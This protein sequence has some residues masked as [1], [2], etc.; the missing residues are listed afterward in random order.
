M[1]FLRAVWEQVYRAW[2]T[3]WF[4]LL[5]LLVYPLLR[6]LISRPEWKPMAHQVHRFWGSAALTLFGMPITIEGREKLD[7]KNGRYVFAP[8][9]SSY[10]DIPL[11]LR[12]IPGFLN[13]VGKSSLARVPL[14]GKIYGAL[15]ICVDRKSQIS[16]A[17]SYAEA[18]NSLDQGRCVTIF[19]EGRIESEISGYALL[20]FQNGPF[21]LAIEKQVPLVP[22]TMP[23]NHYFLPDAQGRL[24]VRYH[25]LKIIFHEPVPTTGMTHHDVEELKS[26]VFDIIQTELT[27]HHY[28][29]RPSDAS[30]PGSLSPA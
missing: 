25:P 15:Y 30:R 2:C 23:Y 17:R 14:W 11:M 29:D 20:P 8:N 5:F 18:K 22:V 19:P 6:I 27:R 28:A 4:G 24:V 9:H 3:F 26:R 10:I 13:F 7:L 12:C 16:R 1:K 21:K